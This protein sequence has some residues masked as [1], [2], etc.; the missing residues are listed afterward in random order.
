MN[1]KSYWETIMFV[2]FDCFWMD[3]R[4]CSLL[5]FRV[6]R[7]CSSWSE[8][9]ENNLEI[10]KTIRNNVCKRC[11]DRSNILDKLQETQDIVNSE[12]DKKLSQYD[13][14]WHSKSMQQACDCSSPCTAAIRHQQTHFVHQCQ[15][16][17]SCA[18]FNQAKTAHGLC[19][20]PDSR[21]SSMVLI[22]LSIATSEVGWA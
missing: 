1:R 9:Q 19:L 21:P 17:P 6:P 15:I 4:Q 16:F 7:H 5:R 3:V 13:F 14:Q 22:W 12:K 2:I 10:K 20:I 18:W 11:W 8:Q